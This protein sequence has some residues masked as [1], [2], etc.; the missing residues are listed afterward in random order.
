M[1]NPFYSIEEYLHNDTFDDTYISHWND[2]IFCFIDT[3]DPSGDI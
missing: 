1:S 2:L 3:Y